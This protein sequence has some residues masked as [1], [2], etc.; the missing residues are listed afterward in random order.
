MHDSGLSASRNDS[1]ADFVPTVSSPP[2]VTPADPQPRP[3]LEGRGLECVRADRV[4][5]TDLSF[6]LHGGEILLVEGGNGTGKT[7]LLRILCGLSLAEEGEILWCGEP[8]AGIREDY[9]ADLA[10]VGHNHGI[11]ILIQFSRTHG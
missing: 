3:R 8:I 9:L 11:S 10:Y 7:S 2:N 1:S 5:F 4:L 6:A